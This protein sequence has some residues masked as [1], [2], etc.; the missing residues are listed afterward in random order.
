MFDAVEGAYVCLEVA[1]TGTGGAT[2]RLYFPAQQVA[3]DGLAEAVAAQLPRGRGETV[4]VVDDESSIR[5]I[6]RQTLEAFGYR[7]LLAANGSEAVSLYVQQPDGVHVVLMDMMMPVM[8]GPATIRVLRRINPDIR[9]IGASGQNSA[10]YVS[11]AT[12]DGATMFLPKPYTAETLLCAV[13]D[14]LMTGP[15]EPIGPST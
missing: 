14:A 11:R 8:D 4:M 1:D 10:E 5:Q 6:A 3:T 7:V 15:V 12:S 13:R 2:F 9:I